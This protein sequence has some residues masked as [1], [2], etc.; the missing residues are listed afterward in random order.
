L[1]IVTDIVPV[2]SNVLCSDAKARSLV[3]RDVLFPSTGSS[4]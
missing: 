2:R 1:P 3:A 4:P